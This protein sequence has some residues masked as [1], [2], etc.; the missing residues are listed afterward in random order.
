MSNAVNVAGGANRWIWTGAIGGV[1][2]AAG[3][4]ALA[5]SPAPSHRDSESV[6]RTPKPTLPP[7]FVR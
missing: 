1:L 3:A 7:G 6:G 5:G 4:L 2:L